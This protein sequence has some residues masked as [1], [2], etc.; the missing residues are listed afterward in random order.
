M[1]FLH[2]LYRALTFWRADPPS[3]VRSNSP[4]TCLSI[5]DLQHSITITSN[6]LTPQPHP[7]NAPQPP[8]QPPD[9]AF[10]KFIFY[11]NMT[12]NEVLSPLPSLPPFTHHNAMIND[13]CTDFEWD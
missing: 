2:S 3:E 1:Q 6:I 11:Q 4:S 7:S 8:L 9:P 12:P 10:S 13:S 5:H